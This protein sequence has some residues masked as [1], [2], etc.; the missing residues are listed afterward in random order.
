[1]TVLDIGLAISLLVI[2]FYCV[3]AGVIL[4]IIDLVVLFV[5]IFIASLLY[6]PFG[7]VLAFIPDGRAAKIA[8]FA[9]IL[10]V[11]II[12]NEVLTHKA[13]IKEKVPIRKKWLDGLLGF[14]VGVVWAG[15]LISSILAIWIAAYPNMTTTTNIKDSVLVPALLKYAPLVPAILHKE[16]DT[17]RSTGLISAIMR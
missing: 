15:V 11:V 14:V 5:G 4:A 17:I 8:A 6:K 1:M 12:V 9:I 16:F 13:K 3:S 10:V 2:S 7:G